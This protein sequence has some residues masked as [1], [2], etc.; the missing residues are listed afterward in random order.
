MLL[1]HGYAMP[2][3]PFQ[4][5][6]VIGS[7]TVTQGGALGYSVW[8]LCGADGISMVRIHYGELGWARLMGAVQVYP[9]CVYDES[10]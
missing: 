6:E 8:P 2:V 3:A 4:G 7:I 10:L 5:F 9:E 1:Y